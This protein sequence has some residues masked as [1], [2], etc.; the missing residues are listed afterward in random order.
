MLLRGAELLTLEAGA[1]PRRADLR[2]EGSRITEL[3][4]LAK[5]PGETCIDLEGRTIC[6]GFVQGH[7][8]LCQTLFR[9][10]AEDL[11]LLDWLRQRIWP[12]EHG[13][14][15][16]SLRRSARLTLAEFARS[17]VTSFQS[18]ESVRGTEWVLDEI[19]HTPLR[20]IVAPSLVDVQ[21][22]EYPPGFATDTKT[23]LD[24]M[25]RLLS[26]WDGK[27]DRIFVAYGPR[28]VLSCTDELQRELGRRRHEEDARIHTHASEHPGELEAV[29]ARFGRKYIQVLADF[30]LLGPRT[31][32]AHCVH[33]D[34]DE[35][36]L[37]VES[38]SAVL[39]CPSTNLKL[40]SGIARIYDFV[41][42]GLRI[43]LGSDGAPANNR[44]DLLTEL[45]SAALLQK[46]RAGE[47]AL[48]AEQ[49]LALATREGARALGL[50]H[51]CGT[52]S[53]GKS[54]DLVVFDLRDP[55]LGEASDPFTKIVYAAGSQHIQRVM[56]GG[57]WL[58]G[59]AESLLG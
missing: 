33:I 11:P 31:G 34:A 59:L 49:S 18:I 47:A 2:V 37:L 1:A 40:G 26:D 28:F 36:E 13:H 57:V 24:T 56:A 15:E 4:E 5:R 30:H 42:R 48:S 16:P 39:H 58:D 17:G 32:L 55:L 12:L 14:D 38:G 6:P 8:H 54:A 25:D 35:E 46:L 44:L 3:G 22:K 51:E 41:Q 10:Q 29:Q 20:A 27:A 21:S 52:L 9:G 50:G 53:P 45:R 43:A 23:A 7:V 19:A